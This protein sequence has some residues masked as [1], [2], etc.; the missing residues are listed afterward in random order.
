MLVDLK[1]GWLI[2]QYEIRLKSERAA[3]WEVSQ[4]DALGRNHVL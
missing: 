2:L 1:S 3:E 4:R